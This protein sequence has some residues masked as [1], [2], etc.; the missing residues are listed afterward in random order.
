MDITTLIAGILAGFVI[1]IFIMRLISLHEHRDIRRSAVKGS[2][3]HIFG[4]VYEKILPALP[5][6]PYNPKDMVF[7]GK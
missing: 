2:K 1:G 7:T 3:N 4:E 5:S 6:F